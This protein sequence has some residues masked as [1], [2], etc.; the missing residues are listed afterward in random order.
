MKNTFFMFSHAF[1]IHS[2]TIFSHS[3]IYMHCNCTGSRLEDQHRN[4][5]LCFAVFNTNKKVPVIS[6]SPP[7]LLSTFPCPQNHPPLFPFYVL[8]PLFSIAVFLPLALS[9]S[10]CWVVYR[11]LKASNT[12]M[13]LQSPLSWEWRLS[14]M[15]N[16]PQHSR[17]RSPPPGP[18]R[19]TTCGRARRAWKWND[20]CER[21]RVS[22]GENES[23]WMMPHVP[24]G[25]ELNRVT[26][27]LANEALPRSLL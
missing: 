22:K 8:L 1:T 13:S 2:A 5:P 14:W 19:C 10:Q 11:M 12:V 27:R 26:K 16:G 4:T 9:I 3:K 6:L 15:L 25:G 23:E 7:S 18:V 17:W 21:G 24:L 20:G